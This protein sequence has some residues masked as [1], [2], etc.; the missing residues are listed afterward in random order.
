[1]GR[2]WVAVEWSEDTLST[3][4]IPRLTKVVNGEDPGGITQK[5]VSVPSEDLPDGVDEGEGRKASTVLKKYQDVGLF[6]DFDDKK[7]N[8]IRKILRDADKS[9]TKTDVVWEGG[10]GFRIL[11]AAPSMFTVD[12]GVVYLAEWASDEAL[13]EPVAAQLGY[14]YEPAPPF[15]GRKGRRRLAVVDGIV[16][17]GVVDI[18]ARSLEEN[19][20]VVIC[21]TA[22]APDA[23]DHLKSISKA[24]RIRKIP[25]SIL[26]EYRL[27]YRRRRT[28][29]LHL[30]DEET[31][32]GTAQAKKPTHV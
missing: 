16:S 13:A 20:S 10:G 27:T 15:C 1:M 22:I 18:L 31:D 11:D 8:R 7:L 12:D 3:F 6:D 29:E 23:R 25:A 14:E 24:S 17:D 19:E 2:R 4:T 21:G 32:A 5:T 28:A 30:P 9:T 26:A